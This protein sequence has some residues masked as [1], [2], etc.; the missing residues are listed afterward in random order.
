M[1]VTALVNFG[2]PA[3]QT[4]RNRIRGGEKIPLEDRGRMVE[5]KEG[6]TIE[7]PADLLQSWLDARLVVPSG[8][9]AT[10]LCP[11]CDVE[12]EMSSAVDWSVVPVKFIDV[13]GYPMPERVKCPNCGA[14]AEMTEAVN[15]EEE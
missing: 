8:L 6:E 3:S 13:E 2:Y 4:V 1:K 7:A 11:A 10:Y 9:H 15:G 12:S 5:V 14:Q